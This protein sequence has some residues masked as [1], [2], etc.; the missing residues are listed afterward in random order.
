MC[1]HDALIDC[2]QGIHAGEADGKHTEV[3]LQTTIDC[4]AASCWI[5]A[6]HILDIVDLPQGE[7]LTIIPVVIVHVL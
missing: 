1:L 4:E 2:L 6:G 3:A 5:H 7:L